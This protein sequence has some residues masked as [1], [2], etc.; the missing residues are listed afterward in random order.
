MIGAGAAG[1]AAGRT[2]AERGRDVHVLEAAPR[3]GGV[4]QTE[5][6]DG[7]VYERGANT[8][9]LT[10]APLAFLREAGLE[11]ALVAASPASRE[12]FLL[13]DGRLVPVPL[14]PLGFVTSPL[15]SVGGKLRLLREPF[16]RRGEGGAESVAAFVERR[17]GREALERLVAPFLVGVYAGDEQQ[18]GA[19]AVFPSLVGY[20]RSAGSIVG[21]AIRSRLRPTAAPTGVAG[22]W[23]AAG[24]LG[25][26]AEAMGQALGERLHTDLPVRGIAPDGAQWRVETDRGEWRARSLLLAVPAPA[27]AQLLAS[28]HAELSELAAAIAYAPMVAVPLSVDPSAA[29]HAIEGFGFLVPGSEGIDLL[30]AL[31]M[32]RLFRNRAP[33]DRELVVAMI[34]GRRWPGAVEADEGVILERVARGLERALGLRSGLDPLEV[35]RWPQAVPQPAVGHPGR[36][37][38]ARAGLAGGPRLELAGAWLDGVSVGDTL[39]SGHAAAKRLLDRA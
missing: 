9:R 11:A 6:R 23:S 14:G 16:V 19:E 39:A 29:A 25:A 37:A 12:R 30:G 7:F 35:I 5:R 36:V 26:L 13:Q 27:A 28:H 2:L 20:E 17:L 21:G 32:S 31:F 22:S 33:A 1:L 18:L 10:G 38:R 24:G 34:G 8:F 15:L 4:L 3:A